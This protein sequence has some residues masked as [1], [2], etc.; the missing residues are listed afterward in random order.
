MGHMRESE[1]A[2]RNHIDSKG[3]VFGRMQGVAR[4]NPRRRYAG[5]QPSRTLIPWERYSSCRQQFRN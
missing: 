4:P 1:L 5:A 2:R 3:R